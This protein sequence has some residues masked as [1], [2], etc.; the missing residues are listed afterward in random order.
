[1][2]LDAKQ[3]V[4]ALQGD[5]TPFFKTSSH[6]A[7][8]HLARLARPDLAREVRK[9]IRRCFWRGTRAQSPPLA[10][11]GLGGAK[12]VLHARRLPC[13][14]ARWQVSFEVLPAD[15]ALLPPDQEKASRDR[16]A[17]LEKELSQARAE[18]AQAKLEL[19]RRGTELR[20]VESDLDNV[21]KPMDLPLVMV[22]RDLKIKRFNS[23]ARKIFYLVS[24]D[25][26]RNITT[27]DT[28]V[29]LPGLLPGLRRAIGG[30]FT[31]EEDIQTGGEVYAMRV[32]P[33][34]DGR[35]EPMGALLMFV[36]KTGLVQAE[37]ERSTIGYVAQL[38][39]LYDD[40][41][42]FYRELPRVLAQRLNFSYAVLELFD[43]EREEAVL[44]GASGL[45]KGEELIQRHALPDSVAGWVIRS[46]RTYIQGRLENRL[47]PASLPLGGL[48]VETLLAVP[49]RVKDAILG[50]IT[51][52]DHRPRK[53]TNHLVETL[54]VVG[55]NAGLGIERRRAQH[56]IIQATADALR[57]SQDRYRK[58]VDTANEG[59]WIVDQQLM[60][61]FANPQ[62]ASMLGY[63][64]EEM[65]GMHAI[66]FIP[67]ADR[68]S[69]LGKWRRTH[70]GLQ[71]SSDWRLLRKDGSQVWTQVS[72]S[73]I[74]DDEGNFS[75]ALAMVADITHR[76][77]TEEELLAH[78]EKLRALASE[79]TMVEERERRRIASDMHDG[80]G[81]LL[82]AC[83]LR[84][85]MLKETAPG[86][87]AAIRGILEIVDQAI[88]TTRSLISDLSPPVLQEMGL[89]AALEWLAERV[90]KISGLSVTAKVSQPSRPISGDMEIILFRAAAELLNNVVKHSGAKRATVSLRDDRDK[91]WLIVEDDG[92]GFEPGQVKMDSFGLF[93][94]RERLTSL[95]GRLEIESRDQ[96]GTRA[97]LSLDLVRA[98]S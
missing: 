42:D 75:G 21:L 11:Q 2:V 25:L 39:L 90:G 72:T 53:V 57:E 34:L 76:K 98:A 55:I 15:A 78:H 69:A 46:G 54:E 58:I 83:K 92:K 12:V 36:E 84:L 77:R 1:M 81:H 94:I 61:E 52:A 17:E 51:L 23:A 33:Y 5:T 40:L 56:T 22:D 47:R 66:D 38:F 48:S 19:R 64:P 24:N 26:G 68:K 63:A 79:L 41:A 67:L 60:T 74:Y 93:S 87:K 18:L 10:L 13:R 91:L 86:Q 95:G 96:T 82:A 6:A 88:L 70:E 45:P 80:V 9:L 27:V 50:V 8:A 71:E 7:A 37:R 32:I 29:P 73:P 85:D 97:S 35:G 16:A 43:K 30:H 14:Q 62:M 44:A 65:L 59:I 49:V 3:R 31:V 4:L 20:D 28:R 89:A